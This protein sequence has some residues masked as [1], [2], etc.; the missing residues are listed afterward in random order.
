MISK[1]PHYLTSFHLTSQ[2]TT[3]LQLTSQP[4]HHTTSHHITSQHTTSPP[5]THHRNTTNHHQTEGLKAGVLKKLGHMLYANSFLGLQ[6]L[7]PLLPHLQALKAFASLSF[8]NNLLIFCCKHQLVC[9]GLF[10]FQIKGFCFQQ[11]LTRL[12]ALTI[13]T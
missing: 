4:Q 13:S 12:F 6:V 8:L 9:F 3:L 7:S 1:Q 5:P 10:S 11:H 2:P